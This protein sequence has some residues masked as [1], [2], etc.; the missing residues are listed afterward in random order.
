MITLQGYQVLELIYSGSK[1]LIY[2]GYRLADQKPVIIK[3]L[4]AEYPSF[5]ELVR[6]RNQYSIARNLNLPGVVQPIA[7]ENYRNHYALVSEDQGA[8]SLEQYQAGMLSVSQVSG[9]RQPIELEEFL[10]IAI[11]L[12]Q[13]LEGLYQ[14]RIVHKDIKPQNIL[15]HPDTK[16][17][18]LID[19]SLSSILP[20]ESSMLQSSTVLEGTLAYLSPE[21]TGRMNRKIDYRADFYSL[22]ITFYELLTGQLPFQA[23]D[24]MELIH[25]H[26][27]QQPLP[28][29]LVNPQIPEMV[30]AIVLKLMAKTA[31]DRY[32]SAFGL[33]CDL[34]RCLSE[35][36][37]QGQISPFS[38]GKRDVCDRFSIPEKLYGREAE[39]AT[40]LAAFDRVSGATPAPE[41][42]PRSELLLVAGFSGIGKT[43]LVN[44]VHK[45]IVR[46][47][48]YFIKG[49]F[50][51]FKRNIPFSAFVQALRDL[52][53]QLLTESAAAIETWRQQILAALGEN[54]AVLIEVIPEL[55]LII[56][57]QPDAPELAGTAAQSRFNLLFQKFIQVFT[58]PEHPLVVF[59]DDLQWA[60]SASLKLIQLM[61]GEV[62]TS[63]LLLIGAYRDNE[64]SPA[65]PLILTLEEVRRSGAIINQITLAP[66]ERSSLN[67]LVADTLSCTPEQALPLSTLVFQKTNGNPFFATQFLKSLH[68]EGFI[69][70]D[71]QNNC[72]Q[73]DIAQV[74]ALAT[75]NNIIEFMAVQLQ[76]LPA[77]TQEILKLA[78]CIGNQ[79]DLNTLS[80]VYDKS[81]TETAAALW[82]ALQAG[83]VLPQSEVYKFYQAGQ[84]TTDTPTSISDISDI[85][86]LPL[87]R[88]LHDRVQQAAY[89]LI[90]DADKQTTHLAIGRLLHQSIDPSALEEHIFEIVNQLN[91]GAELIADPSERNELA[92]LNLVAGRKAKL[93]TAYTAAVE[94]LTT[95]LKL[96]PVDRWQQDYALSLTF[97]EEAAD[98]A[99]LCGNFEQMSHWLAVIQNQ[100]VSLLDRI[101]AS[102]IQILAYI[103]QD[104]P[105]A[106]LNTAL[107]VLK[108]LGVSLPTEP[109]SYHVW[110]ALWKTRLALLGRRVESLLDLP[111]MTDPTQLAAMRVLA[112]VMSAAYAS[113]PRLFLLIALKVL[114][115]SLKHGNV[116]LSAY[117]YG[118]YGQI[119][120]SVVGD[121]E[122]GYQFGQLAL[123][124]LAKLNAKPLKAKIL[125]V[126]NDFVVHWKAH[127]KETLMPF[128]EAYQSGLETGDLEFASRSAMVYAYHSYFIGQDLTTLEQELGNYTVAIRELKQMK[129]I[130]MNER[131]RQ[132]VLNLL[133]R[134]A[135]PCR[136]VGEAYNEDELLP[137]HFQANDRNAV[138]NVYFHKAILCYLFGE[139]QQA[140]QYIRQSKPFLGNATGLLLVPLFHFYESLILLAIVGTASAI[141]RT[142]ILQQVNRN[143]QKLKKWA[144]FA[145]MN[146]LHKF[147]LVEA[148]RY[149]VLQR[150]SAAMEAYD[151]AIALAEEHEY[152]NETAL[153]NE[154][155]ARFYLK[156]GKEK[157]A[158]VYL[159]EAYSHYSRWGAQAKV[160]DL[161]QR[162]PLL[163]TALAGKDSLKLRDSSIGVADSDAESL[164][165]TTITASGLNIS[166]ALD[167]ETVL[168]ASQALSGEI[169]IE[170]LLTTLMQVVIENAGAEKGLLILPEADGQWLIQAKVT[171]EQTALG[172]IGKPSAPISHL[173]TESI[174]V[175]AILQSQPLSSSPDLPSSVINYVSRTQKELTL[176][177]ASRETIFAADPYI[178]QQQPKSVLCIPILNQGNLV[179]ILYLENNLTTGA[180][181]SDRLQ[182]LKLLMTQAAISL[183]NAQLYERVKEYSHTL[184]ARIET[185][186]QELHQEVREREQAL[187]ALR[188]AQANLS[189]RNESLRLIVEG[190]AAKIGDE[191]FRSCARYLAELLNVKYVYVSEYTNPEKD[192]LR[193]LAFWSGDRF[194]ENCEFA[195]ANTPCGALR[196]ADRLCVIN[197]VQEQF[198]HD[199][200]LIEM[201]A[202]SYVGMVIANPHGNT[203]GHLCALHTQPIA[204]S[205]EDLELIFKI[206]AARASAE[207]ERRN[208]EQALEQQMQRVLLL[209][210]I[211]Q[212][213]RQSLDPK[214]VFQSAADQIGRTF[215]VDRC[216]IHSYVP[217]P[218][219]HLVVVAEYLVPDY[220]SMLGLEIPLVNNPPAEQLV[221]HDRAFSWENVYT[222]PLLCSVISETNPINLKSMLAIRTSYQGEL[223][224][225]I[226]LHHC[227]RPMSRQ[228]YLDRQAPEDEILFR[229][230][231][232]DEIQLVEAVAAQVGIAL[233]QA[234]LLEQEKLRRQELEAAKRDAEIANKAKSEFLANMSHEL[235]T[236][237]NA[238]LGFTQL[239]LRDASLNEM[240]LDSLQIISRSGSHLLEL[241]NDV[242][243]FSKIEAGRMTLSESSF[244]LFNLLNALEEMFRLK[245]ET[246]G[247]R[248]RFEQMSDL[249]QYIK[250][251][252]GKLRQVLINLLSNA[253][254]F[255]PVGNV[256][257]RVGACGHPA[258]DQAGDWI[259]LRFEVEDTGPGIQVEEI[260]QL[261]NA[262]VQTEAGRKSKEGTGLGLSISR[263][264][265]RL[266]GGAIA[267]ENAPTQGAIFKFTI[268]AQIAEDMEPRR[269]IPHRQVV[270]LA[271][272]QPTYRLLIVE[273][274]WT[275]RQ[276]LIKL[277]S[278]LGFEVQEAENGREAIALWQQWQPHLIWMDMRMPVMDGYEATKQ[279]KSHPNGNQTIIIALTASAFEEERAVVLASGC[280]D[281][282]RKPFQ[283]QVIFEKMAE[284]LGIQYIYREESALGSAEVV[285]I[286]IAPDD[287]TIMPPTWL[288]Q[289][290]QA[291]IQVDATQ[292]HQLLQEIP[293]THAA[294]A[295]QLSH[296]T[297]HYCFDEILDLTQRSDDV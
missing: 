28:P 126:V 45:P 269:A 113:S 7:L 281:F 209:D 147:Y 116:G 191:F 158:Q 58:T 38:L 293:G 237:L 245:A 256:V 195:I 286:P 240:Q 173:P 241:I 202:E 98:A 220:D 12:A 272:N 188:Q 184:E 101:R 107:A 250:T 224:G 180:F 6:F 201:E 265:V 248:L 87:Y 257:L 296:L 255:T 137:L 30:E 110:L 225:A 49:K 280:D 208:A 17:I 90:P 41:A 196:E 34:E 135:D 151:Q 261:F 150:N 86:V 120:C 247:L 268:Q 258:I 212:E 134:S 77:S 160:E 154:L 142:K 249:P 57:Q 114:N 13:I 44:E 112:S 123:N 105:T 282:V 189:R 108:P 232:E 294:L 64:V 20:E 100:A 56:G 194:A 263:E 283:E 205:F 75:S 244:D 15:I 40:L 42:T 238:I 163:A 39:V 8:I 68:Q 78:A 55:E 235:R 217:E 24:P 43:A 61:I 143:Q 111:T 289:L 259:R 35:W 51:Q 254:K 139:S 118:T 132:V 97:Y 146:H 72:W 285:P 197:G 96:L 297:Q 33:K 91:V 130:Y 271:P 36:R 242:L 236:P 16:Q 171:K 52:M 3:L 252:E 159:A 109:Q 136:L 223:N 200:D 59:L 178:R 169:Q 25:C 157:F 26:I 210:K 291:A 243:E 69:S 106:A 103:A 117:A 144:H 37:S 167:L 95:G 4:K 62:D 274:Q 11:Q 239:L 267:A 284:H 193:T 183:E 145:P 128:I 152:E 140:A 121:I 292:I 73:C 76:K 10:A 264:F 162:Y 231:T 168:R 207:L 186:T 148:E 215:K 170:Q 129:F 218:E 190:T 221:S 83:L 262:F 46:Q 94:Y 253:I 27:A 115:L 63:Y 149:R 182:V 176:E 219:P 67:R 133:G 222:N 85:E 92:Q 48:G 1:T 246:K 290:R 216:H 31:E 65:H 89:S 287:L 84:E 161:E 203:L 80:V 273:D 125:L 288:A 155:A 50:D 277:L 251:D 175:D 60:D 53:Q 276:L 29:R 81:P 214:Q 295:R 228:E 23:T 141:D 275:N 266:M 93:A 32:Q 21:Q 278:P 192:F 187:R 5:T 213:I 2:R 260:E 131:Y 127:V 211:T 174:H 199:Q 122:T 185:R 47:R 230:W 179:G 153:A 234:N 70:F 54:G 82:G 18:Q 9:I 177:N 227:D 166:R 22:G 104:Q 233:A 119:L 99:Y 198:P 172:Q 66:L 181:T 279:I 226:V 88:F 71:F 138:F 229:Q 206:F 165:K 270:S 79:F 19:F 102:E 164:V 204:D 156:Q 14:Y 124:L 74:K